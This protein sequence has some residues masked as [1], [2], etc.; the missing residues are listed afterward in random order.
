MCPSLTPFLHITLTSCWVNR[1]GSFSEAAFDCMHKFTPKYFCKV[2]Y[3]RNIASEPLSL[4]YCMPLQRT[5][6]ST[7]CIRMFEMFEHQLM[8][9]SLHIWRRPVTCFCKCK[10]V[11]NTPK[12][13]ENIILE[14]FGH[15]THLHSKEI[16]DWR[17]LDKSV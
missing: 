13:D 4:K 5:A 7:I 11:L 16:K 3:G 8:E 14:M 6:V 10:N 17:C 12:S 9:W 15:L 1:P 2:Q